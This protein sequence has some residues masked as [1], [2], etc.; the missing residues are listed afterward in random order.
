MGGP[1]SHRVQIDPGTWRESREEGRSRGAGR[2]GREKEVS[3]AQAGMGRGSAEM[4]PAPDWLHLAFL[5]P[6]A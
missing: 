5:G 6:F 4:F 2:E 3:G 1:K